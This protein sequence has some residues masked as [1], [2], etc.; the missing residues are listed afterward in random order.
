MRDNAKR[1]GLNNLQTPGC[2]GI[3]LRRKL[4]L[5]VVRELLRAGA[6]PK[7][8]NND[9]ETPMHVA[10]GNGHFSLANFL[11]QSGGH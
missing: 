2:Y 6:D 10:L 8:A 7:A 9:G 3:G 5:D 4:R 1:Y 11:R